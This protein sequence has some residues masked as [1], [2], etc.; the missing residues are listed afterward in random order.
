MVSRDPYNDDIESLLQNTNQDPVAKFEDFFSLFERETKVFPYIKAI[1]GMVS[2]NKQTS[3]FVNFTDLEMDNSNL[4]MNLQ[5]KPVEYIKKANQALV[6]LL[7]SASSGVIRLD[8][9][10]HFVRFFNIPTQFHRDIGQ[11][12][13]SDRYKLIQLSGTLMSVSIIYQ[14]LKV[15][16]FECKLCGAPH[17]IEQDDPESRTYPV[18]CNIG[19]CKNQAKKDF[20]FVDENSVYV[21]YQRYRV[22]QSAEDTGGTAPRWIDCIARNDMMDRCVPGDRIEIVGYITNK[23]IL[24]NKDDVAIYDK[25]FIV[26]NIYKQEKEIISEIT[27]EEEAKFIEVSKSPTLIRDMSQS[28]CT[29]HYGDDIVKESLFITT[30]S[31]PPFIKPNGHADR[32][33]SHVL[34]CGDPSGGKSEL[35]KAALALCEKHMFT[36]GGGVSGVGLIGAIQKDEIT[37]RPFVMGG[38]LAIANDG[39]C[40]IDELDKM[41]KEDVKKIHGVLEDQKSFI[42]KNGVNSELNCKT[43]CICACNPKFGVWRKDLNWRENIDLS[44]PLISRF[45]L[46]WIFRDQRGIER[47]TGVGRR[48]VYRQ[49]EENELQSFE[50]ESIKPVYSIDFMRKYIAYARKNIFPVLTKEAAD[51]IVN[52][53][54]KMRNMKKEDGTLLIPIDKSEEDEPLPMVARHIAGL[55]RLSKDYARAEYKNKVSK[56]H[57]KR[58]IGLFQESLKQVMVDENG[59]I[60]PRL[61]QTGRSHNLQEKIIVVYKTIQDLIKH[62]SKKAEYTDETSIIERLSFKSINAEETKK[63]LEALLSEEKIVKSKAGYKVKG[64]D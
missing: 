8:D 23:P 58:A 31:S 35:I 36:T 2:D 7:Y 63:C 21:D 41:Q 3:L 13:K 18:V 30:L 9:N 54:V 44:P 39:T 50:L 33:D 22:Q 40:G 56:D 45:D 32:G 60:D 57:V 10:E 20:R 28:L 29:D 46:I 49:L 4:A 64:Y 25:K 11:T 38:A 5:K 59:N 55:T 26:N 51:E 1:Q 42:S 16:A 62:D 52:F 15:A 43:R 12:R 61:I 47:D 53:Y 24:G 17:D 14:E 34:L 48:I 6:N 19:G 27:Q 37:G